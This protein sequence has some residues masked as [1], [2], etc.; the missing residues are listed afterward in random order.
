[1]PFNSLRIHPVAGSFAHGGIP[2]ISI[3][4]AKLTDCLSDGFTCDHAP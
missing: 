3:K 2:S 4:V 1:M